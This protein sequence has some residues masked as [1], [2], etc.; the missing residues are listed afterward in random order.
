[1]LNNKNVSLGLLFVITLLFY[2]M[3]YSQSDMPGCS[4]LDK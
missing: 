1:M 2:N 3:A 4:C